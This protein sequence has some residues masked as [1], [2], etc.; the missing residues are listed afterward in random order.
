[1]ASALSPN[2]SAVQN[3]SGSS[4]DTDASHGIATAHATM[5][6][7]AVSECASSSGRVYGA[8]LVD[9]R[10]TLT[11]RGGHALARGGLTV[12]GELRLRQ[13]HLADQDAL[14]VVRRD[15]VAVLAAVGDGGRRAG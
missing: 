15:Q 10:P 11:G 13:L 1:M 12:G 9:M 8:L 3:R 7:P 2:T 6:S 4:N 14:E 5:P